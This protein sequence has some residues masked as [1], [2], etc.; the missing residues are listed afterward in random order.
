MRAVCE[1]AGGLGLELLGRTYEKQHKARCCGCHGMLAY[2]EER[3]MSSTRVLIVRVG[4]RSVPRTAELRVE[5]EVQTRQAEGKVRSEELLDWRTL[6]LMAKATIDM[7]RLAY[8][9]PVTCY[10]TINDHA[11]ASVMSQAVDV[12]DP[13]KCLS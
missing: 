9:L 1:L 3:L 7:L 2:V 12:T 4:S 5:A 10:A 13:F 11:D 8:F 6:I